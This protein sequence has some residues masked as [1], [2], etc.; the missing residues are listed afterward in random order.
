MSA[1][2]LNIF[3]TWVN[4]LSVT[5]YIELVESIPVTV[6]WAGLELTTLIARAN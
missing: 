5:I 1:D 6:I 2:L 4:N 3:Y